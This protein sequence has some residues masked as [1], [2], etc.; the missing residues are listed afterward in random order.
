MKL[1]LIRAVIGWLWRHHKYLVME[2][3]APG[4]HL[5]LNPKRK[6]VATG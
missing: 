6:K 3:I 2:T 1:R 4:K 5:H